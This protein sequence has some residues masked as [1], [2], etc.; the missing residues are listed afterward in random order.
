[1]RPFS[2]YKTF[3]LIILLFTGIKGICQLEK[4]KEFL[5]NPSIDYIA[6]LL[7][8]INAPFFNKKYPFTKKQLLSNDETMLYFKDEDSVITLDTSRLN[9]ETDYF[10]DILKLFRK[11][12]GDCGW[13]PGTILFRYYPGKIAEGYNYL[14]K[15]K[16]HKIPFKSSFEEDLKNK[17][18]LELGEIKKY[19]KF[20]SY[21]Y[22]S[23]NGSGPYFYGAL[24]VPVMMEDKIIADMIK[25]GLFLY[26]SRDAIECGGGYTRIIIKRKNVFAGNPQQ[27]EGVNF[28]KAFFK[29]EIDAKADVTIV[30]QSG[31]AYDVNCIAPSKYISSSGNDLWEKMTFSIFFQNG[32]GCK[33]DE[34]EIMVRFESAGYAKGPENIKP[35]IVR[36]KTDYDYVSETTRFAQ[37]LFSDM[38]SEFGGSVISTSSFF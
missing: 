26:A 8:D 12:P 15:L 33:P 5:K 27:S 30:P 36:F 34:M 2:A 19:K 20:Y 25:S 31:F 10:Y 1:M 9:V 29:K 11:K 16:L 24:K 35:P 21:T 17:T 18:L 38:A 14:Q 37:K 23:F 28:L 4:S 22:S 7:N 13:V 6:K 3:L 32:F